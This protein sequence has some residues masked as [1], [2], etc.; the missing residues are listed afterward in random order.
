MQ[1]IAGAI[2]ANRLPGRQEWQ[3]DQSKSGI[4]VPVFI[5]IQRSKSLA[6]D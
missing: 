6:A 1:S 4:P 2:T 3:R 5:L